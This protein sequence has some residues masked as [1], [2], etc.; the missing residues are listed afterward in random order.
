MVEGLVVP[1][2]QCDDAAAEEDEAGGDSCGEAAKVRPDGDPAVAGD[3]SEDVEDQPNESETPERHFEGAGF[4]KEK[5]EDTDSILWI[6]GGG[7]ADDAVDGA[8]GPDGCAAVEEEVGNASGDAEDEVEKE[9]GEGNK[10]GSE[11]D[12]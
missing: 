2:G 12:S 11:L 6:Q 3:G 9:V 1:C 5:P 7:H 4:D 8:A 10:M